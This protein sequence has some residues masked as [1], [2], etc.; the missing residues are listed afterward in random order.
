MK[1]PP[2]AHNGSSKH[3]SKPPVKGAGK[4]TKNSAVKP[5]S[6]KK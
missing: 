1:K 5:M 6:K 2:F 3:Q 4:D